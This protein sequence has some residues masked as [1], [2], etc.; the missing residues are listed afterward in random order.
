M[1]VYVVDASVAGKWFAD[2]EHKEAA[3]RALSGEHELHAPD[4]LLVE[5]DNVVCKWLRRGLIEVAEADRIRRDLRALPMTRYRFLPLLDSAYAIA[6]ETG[7]SVYD[8]LYVALAISLDERVVTADRR[9]YN[10]LAG[11]RFGRYVLWVEAIE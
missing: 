8:S 6:N 2:E 10:A 11:G 1:S 9:F 5:M 4:F 7:R 3:R